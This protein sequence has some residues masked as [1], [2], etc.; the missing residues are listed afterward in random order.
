MGVN[1]HMTKNQ[2]QKQAGQKPTYYVTVSI[3]N[4][5]GTFSTF[6]IIRSRFTGNRR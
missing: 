5:D 3:P 6:Q 1:D 4:G 2:N